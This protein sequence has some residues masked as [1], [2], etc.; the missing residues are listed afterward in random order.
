ME[1]VSSSLINQFL[2]PRLGLK[3]WRGSQSG[4][5]VFYILQGKSYI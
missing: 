3:R 4:E 1:G 2:G 5:G